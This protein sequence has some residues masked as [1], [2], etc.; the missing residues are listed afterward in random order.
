[1][2][3]ISDQAKQKLAD[4]KCKRIILFCQGGAGDV[5]AHTPMI[6]GMR[7]EYPDDLII[8]LSTYKQLLEHNPN[9]DILFPLNDIQ[10]FYSEFV[11]SKNV[12][13]FK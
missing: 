9:I 6:R 4:E 3:N 7:N 8:V 10:D 13:F 11:I 5:L 1:V 2:L 12:R